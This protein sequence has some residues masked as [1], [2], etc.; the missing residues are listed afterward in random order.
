MAAKTPS[1]LTQESV[2]SMTAYI[3]TFTDLDDTDTW[4]S[5]I[6]GAKFWSFTRTDNPSTQTAVGTAVAITAAGVA[7][8][9]P[10]EDNT[11]GKLI[12]YT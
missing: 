5:G 12:I 4:T 7:T 10:A 3:A 2:G 11:A 8:F 9:Y 6:T 1:T